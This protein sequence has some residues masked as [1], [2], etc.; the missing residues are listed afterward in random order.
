LTFFLNSQEGQQQEYFE[1]VM[2]VYRAFLVF[3]SKLPH[4]PN[5]HNNKS[6]IVQSDLR[7]DHA[8]VPPRPIH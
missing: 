1:F 7:G 4:W 3:S 5:P 6:H 8:F 2:P